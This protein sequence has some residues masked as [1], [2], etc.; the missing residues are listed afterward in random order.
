MEIIV[1]KN[2]FRPLGSVF[3]GYQQ[4]T[5]LVRMKGS[6]P[7][8]VSLKAFKTNDSVLKQLI[9]TFDLEEDLPF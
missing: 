6:Y 1:E 5:G 4:E 9:K 3:L 7:K 8:R 2:A